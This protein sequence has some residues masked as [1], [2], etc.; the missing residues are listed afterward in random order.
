MVLLTNSQG[1]FMRKWYV[2]LTVLGIGG[3][4][5]F[6]LTDHGKRVVRWLADNLQHAPEML[7]EWNDT[8]Q[9]ELDKIQNSLNQVA[10]SLEGLS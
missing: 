1:D 8:A 6:F 10:Q 9:A 7:L 5:L 2:P 4:S 3:I